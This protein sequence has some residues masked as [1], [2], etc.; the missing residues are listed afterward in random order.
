[1]SVIAQ[2]IHSTLFSCGLIK[3]LDFTATFGAVL[4]G[5]L[6][7]LR[8]VLMLIKERRCTIYNLRIAQNRLGDGDVEDLGKLASLM[9][10]RLKLTVRQ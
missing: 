6:G 9:A 10:F 7:I 4:S 8:P 1:M 3:E 5:D 2:E